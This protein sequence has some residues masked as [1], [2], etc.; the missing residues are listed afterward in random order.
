MSVGKRYILDANV[1]IEAQKGYYAIDIC[2]GFWQA[3]VRQHDARR[4]CSID[5]IRDELLNDDL[6]RWV[7]NVSP[8]GFFKATADKEVIKAFAAMVNWVQGESQF[9]PQAKAEFAAVADGWLIA[10][11][12][13]N[14]LAVVT[15]EQ[16]AP[17]VKNKVPI[18][19]VCSEFGVVY[20]NTFEMLREMKE[21]FVLRRRRRSG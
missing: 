17:E 9:A 11:A 5:K 14:R 10:F 15:H 13:V 18:P 16:Y 21:Q 1:F 2:P 7:R 19:N 12:K 8:Q 3:L 6:R 20:C 4:V